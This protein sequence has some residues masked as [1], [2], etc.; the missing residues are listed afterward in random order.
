M[1]VENEIK[2]AGDKII[3][4]LSLDRDEIE[5]YAR[6]IEFTKEEIDMKRLSEI[7]S[8]DIN[9]FISIEDIFH[10]YLVDQAEEK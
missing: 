5:R 10:E 6:D 9:D 7:I 4:Q 3:F 1:A 8:L 2:L